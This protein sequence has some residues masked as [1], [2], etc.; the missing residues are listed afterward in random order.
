MSFSIPLLEGVARPFT[1]TAAAVLVPLAL[2]SLVYLDAR[3]RR[4]SARSRG[5]SLTP[6]AWGATTFFSGVGCV[7]VAACYVAVRV[8]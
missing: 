3:R 4:G 1:V 8:R 2:A 6:L 5:R 7:V